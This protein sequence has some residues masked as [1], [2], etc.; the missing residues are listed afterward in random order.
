MKKRLDRINE[1]I[2]IVT[3]RAK[4]GDALS[5]MQLSQYLETKAELLNDA[6]ILNESKVWRQK[7]IDGGYKAPEVDTSE[8][9]ILKMLEKSLPKAQS[10]YPMEKIYYASLLEAR[11]LQKKDATL[12]D[13]AE[14]WYKKSV[15]QDP[16]YQDFL[17]NFLSSKPIFL[18]EINNK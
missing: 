8:A 16:E 9:G 12:L 11:A 4:S 2:E 15:E 3:Q 10:G 14:S 5:Q 1:L 18:E 7:S 17:E 13:E 6:S